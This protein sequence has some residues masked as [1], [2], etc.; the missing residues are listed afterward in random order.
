[1]A[2]DLATSSGG[3]LP[4]PLGSSHPQVDC[5]VVHAPGAGAARLDRGHTVTAATPSRTLGKTARVPCGWAILGLPR[6]RERRWGSRDV[7]CTQHTVVPE[8]K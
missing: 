1:V 2:A 7:R 4:S 3:R 5:Q 6:V 8:D